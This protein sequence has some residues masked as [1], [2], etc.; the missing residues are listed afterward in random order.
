MA[1]LF[2]SHNKVKRYQVGGT[3]DHYASYE[4]KPIGKVKVDTSSLL[5]KYQAPEKPDAEKVKKALGELGDVKGGGLE[6]DSLKRSQEYNAALARLE[7]GLSQD[8]DFT[9]KCRGNR[10]NAHFKITRSTSITSR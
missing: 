8:I 7:Q 9:K 4:Y 5:Q 10:F 2:K 1:I 6:N 3:V